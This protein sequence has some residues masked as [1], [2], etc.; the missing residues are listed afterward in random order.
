[1]VLLTGAGL[2]LSSLDR[3]HH[4]DTG[5]VAENVLLTPLNLPAGQYPE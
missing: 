3:L 2:L 5:F 4:T 1:M